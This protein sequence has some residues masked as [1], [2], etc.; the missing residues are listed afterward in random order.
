EGLADTVVAGEAEYIWPQFCR[1]FAAGAPAEL[2]RETGSVDLAHSPV[3]RF[4]LLPLNKYSTVGI[5]YSRG[6]P[7]RC[8]FCDIVVMFGRQP[9]HKRVEQI[10]A[11]LDRLRAAG[12][13]N[14]FFVDDNLI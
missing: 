8:D 4:D 1:D 11:E 2:Y 12:V 14:V 3:P 6:C 7:F 10:G 9:R 5:Q 13:R